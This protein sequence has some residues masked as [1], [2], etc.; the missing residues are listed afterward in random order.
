[1]VMTVSM[2]AGLWLSRF[3][4]RRAA[5]TGSRLLRTD[6][7]HYAADV[8]TSGGVLLALGLQSFT[9]KQ[10]I[11]P[12]SSLLIALWI[13]W[14]VRPI[15]AVAVDGS[16]IVTVAQQRAESAH[17]SGML[18]TSS[19]TTRCE[20]SGRDR[21]SASTSRGHLHERLSGRTRSCAARGRPRPPA[22]ADVPCTPIR[23]RARPRGPRPHRTGL[24]IRGMAAG[25]QPVFYE[26]VEE[27]PPQLRHELSPAAQA[28]YVEA[29]NREYARTGSPEGSAAVAESRL[30]PGYVR[31]GERWVKRTVV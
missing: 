11:D 22:H 25:L 3:L 8:W 14:E 10:W 7:L 21:G 27:L 19:P 16:W 23:A 24:D 26:S 29:F 30:T 4:V 1:M 20:P 28:E 5:E 9:G 6:S 17:P 12:A 13:L 18:P 2:L 31:E 15:L